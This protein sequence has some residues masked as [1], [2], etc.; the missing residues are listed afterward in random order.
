MPEGEALLIEAKLPISEIGYVRMGAHAR[1]SIA[2]GGNGF[3]TI[4]ATVVHISP[5][6]TSD[7]KAS[8]PA[9]SYYVVRLQPKEPGFRRNADFYPLRPGVQVTAAVITGER[10][11]MGLLL[12]P[13]LGS[14]VHPLTER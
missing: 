9:Q 5:D 4:S 3:S 14:G 13:F 10:S 8:G 12:D 7:E 1:L 6:A 2:S 11:V